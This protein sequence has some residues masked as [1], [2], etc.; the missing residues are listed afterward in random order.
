MR[1]WNIMI[2]SL[3]N[4]LMTNCRIMYLKTSDDTLENVDGN[5]EEMVEMQTPIGLDAAT[6]RKLTESEMEGT[7]LIEECIKLGIKVTTT[8]GVRRNVKVTC[9]EDRQM[10]VAWKFFEDNAEKYLDGNELFG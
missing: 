4:V 9:Y 3:I 8:D 5:A 6:V 10:A 1:A 7:S 2:I